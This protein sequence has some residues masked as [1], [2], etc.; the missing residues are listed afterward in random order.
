M[1]RVS[2]SAAFNV[3]IRF[4]LEMNKFLTLDQELHLV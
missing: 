3:F 2:H 1:M 4:S